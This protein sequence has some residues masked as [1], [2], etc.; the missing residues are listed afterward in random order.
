MI[1]RAN[2]HVVRRALVPLIGLLLLAAARA[3][4]A[5]RAG[6]EDLVRA[7]SL[8]VHGVVVDHTTALDPAAG[9][10]WTSYR[11]RVVAA[12]SGEAAGEIVVHVR[13]G[14]SGTLEQEVL[15]APRLTDGERVVAFLGPLHD[16]SREIVGLAQ[17]AFRVETDARTGAL[18]CSNSVDGLSLVDRDGNEVAADPLHLSL[19]ELTRRVSAARDLVTAEQQA[20]RDALDRRL[21]TWRRAA[22]RHA[23]MTR[24]RPGGAR[25]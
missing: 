3:S 16:G 1:G 4:I 13:G 5:V 7:S 23:L 21:A 12:I 18:S 9:A 2:L 15:G 20:A 8:V 17:G 11:V 14:R 6:V 19:E 24:G 22:E 10:I 25:D